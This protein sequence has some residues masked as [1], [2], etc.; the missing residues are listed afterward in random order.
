MSHR[1]QVQINVEVTKSSLKKDVE[2][3]GGQDWHPALD[4]GLVFDIKISTSAVSTDKKKPSPGPFGHEGDKIGISQTLVS[5]TRRATYEGGGV[6]SVLRTEP[7]PVPDCDTNTVPWYGQECSPKSLP[8]AGKSS[9]K[10]KV[11]DE[12][13]GPFEAEARGADRRTH[14][15]QSVHMSEK[16]YITVYNETSHTLIKQWEWS[17]SYTVDSSAVRAGRTRAS[18]S[19]PNE[20]RHIRSIPL[21]GSG[22]LRTQRFGWTAGWGS[23]YG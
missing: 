14:K 11:R 20:V 22:S 1:K 16:F 5:S 17:Y 12:P 15:I 10:F 2:V 18:V 3:T 6:C 7:L 9:I 4:P 19:G 8:A 13:G 23:L 21:T